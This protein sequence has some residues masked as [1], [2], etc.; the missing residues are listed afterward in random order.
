LALVF[1]CAGQMMP[2]CSWFMRTRRGE[3]NADPQ[4]PIATRSGGGGGGSSRR[5][6]IFPS[7]DIRLHHQD[8]P[9]QARDYPSAHRGACPCPC[10]PSS[11]DLNSKELRFLTLPRAGTPESSSPRDKGKKDCADPFWQLEDRSAAAN[12]TAACP[13]A[14]RVLIQVKTGE[15]RDVRPFDKSCYAAMEASRPI[16]DPD[17][18]PGQTR[19]IVPPLGRRRFH[20]SPGLHP[21]TRR[22]RVAN[23][24]HP[25]PVL[26]VVAL[27]SRRRRS[28]ISWSPSVPMS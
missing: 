27:E 22:R 23:R 12:G 16:D 25:R 19:C 6:R 17:G 3:R 10:P 9:F 11:A 18:E 26:D 2:S 1:P 4:D 24:P 5:R 15:G 13:R 20:L 8:N 14:L 21:S 28:C 7:L